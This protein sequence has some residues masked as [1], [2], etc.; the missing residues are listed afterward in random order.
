MLYYPIYLWRLNEF[1]NIHPTAGFASVSDARPPYQ[2]QAAESP[3]RRR[4]SSSWRSFGWQDLSQSVRRASTTSITSRYYTCGMRQ[5]SF[6]TNCR[7]MRRSSCLMFTSTFRESRGQ[8]NADSA[9]PSSLQVRLGNLN[10]RLQLPLKT[11]KSLSLVYHHVQLLMFRPFLVLRGKLR[12]PAPQVGAESCDKLR[13][14]TWLDT[15]CEYCVEP[16]RQ[17]IKYINKSCEINHLCKVRVKEFH[18]PRQ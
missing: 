10:L 8:E 1:T 7:R 5:R 6:A 16:A 12:T 18:I 9:R 14:L 11:N 4:K 17:I 13:E 15:A 2:T 3:C